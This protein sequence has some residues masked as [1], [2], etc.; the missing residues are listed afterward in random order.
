MTLFESWFSNSFLENIIA[1]ESM[2]NLILISKNELTWEMHSYLCV[3][4]SISLND[5][6]ISFLII[7]L[8][9]IGELSFNGDSIST[10]NGD[11]VSG[12]V[13]RILIG[14]WCWRASVVCQSWSLIDLGPKQSSWWRLSDQVSNQEV[15]SV[16]N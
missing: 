14:F 2:S 3:A 12:R 15:D 1:N 10:L 9:F 11:F 4:P 8:I 7:D 16:Q 5:H 13:R 6:S